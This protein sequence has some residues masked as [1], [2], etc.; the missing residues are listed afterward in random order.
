[1]RGFALILFVWAACISPAWAK[2]IYVATNGQHIA[3]FTN[4]WLAATNI[5]SAVDAAA[6]GDIVLV[7]MGT[8]ALPAP[9]NITKGLA[10]KSVHGPQATILSGRGTVRGLYL[11][12][13]NA[14]VEGF[15]IRSCALS[16]Y[17]SSIVAGA[18]IFV[19]AGA[20]ID[21]CII[22]S[23]RVDGYGYTGGNGYGGGA[24]IYAAGSVTIRN[25]LIYD[26]A[27]RGVGGESWYDIYM[28]SGPPGDGYGKGGGL[29]AAGQIN[30]ENC[31]IAGNQAVGVG[32]A[33]YYGGDGDGYAEGGGIF[34]ASADAFVANSIIQS[35]WA[36]DVIQN[37]TGGTYSH[38]CSVPQPEGTGNI[39]DSPQFID[40]DS[41]D[42]RLTS[43]SPCIG[44]G[45]NATV[46]ADRDLA[47][48]PRILNETVD[49]GSYE[50]LGTSSG[51]R[52]ALFPDEAIA[53]GA[54][55]QV[56][57]GAWQ[58]SGT[59]VAGLP[60]GVHTVHCSSVSG[61]V[62][63]ADQTAA[64]AT[65]QVAS[66]NSLYVQT[67][68][69]E[70]GVHP[71]SQTNIVGASVSFSIVAGGPDPLLYQWQKNAAPISGATASQY[72]LAPLVLSDSGAY[73]C[74]VSNAYGAITSRIANLLVLDGT[75]YVRQDNPTPAWPYTTWNT[76]ATNIQDAIDAAGGP[77]AVVLV[78]NGLYQTGGRAVYG[79][80]RVVIDKPIAMRSVNGPAVTIIQG[81]KDPLTTNGSAAVRCVW[82]TNNA[83]LAGFTLTNGATQ[84]SWSDNGSGGGVWCLSGNATISNCIL[85]GNSAYYRSGGAHQGTLNNCLLT[86]NI[87]ANYGGGTSYST[88]NN[89]TLS[90]NSASTYGGGSY[91]GSLNNTVIYFNSAPNGSNV[92][93]STLNS[94]CSSPLAG[95]VG[96]ID[97]DPLFLGR[98]SGDFRLAAGSPCIDKGSNALVQGS[99]DLNGQP[100]IAGDFVD[101]G[102]IEFAA[103]A[104]LIALE[105]HRIVLTAKEEQPIADQ[106]IQVWNGGVLSLD[107]SIA[108]NVPWLA[109]HPVSGSSTGKRDVVAV[110]FSTTGL[111]AG[112]HTGLVTIS[113]AQAD[114]SPRTVE[115]VLTVIPMVLDHF[116][117]AMI[118]SPQQAGVPFAVELAA[119][120]EENLTV[121]WF[122]NAVPL[123]AWK[124]EGVAAT[125][126]GI[127]AGSYSAGYPMGTYYNNQRTQVIYLAD[128]IGSACSITSLAL[129]VTAVPGQV[130]QNWTIRMKHTP[131]AL[132]PASPAWEGDGWTTAYQADEP[133]GTTGWRTF[134]FDAP[135]E[136]NGTD[137]LMVDFSF[138]C[139]YW[140]YYDGECQC[141]AVS[142]N[143][144]ITCQA[145][146]GYGDPLTWAGAWPSPY[147]EANIPNIQLGAIAGSFVPVAI[148]PE[149]TSAFTSGVWRGAITIGAETAD[150]FLRA[151]D[152]QGHRGDSVYFNVILALADS[153]GDGLPDQWEQ[154]HYG[155]PT[156]AN[157]AAWASNLLN[158]VEQAYLAGIDPNSPDSFFRV[159]VSGHT[160]AQ[161][162]LSWPWIPGRVYSVYWASNLISPQSW[163]FMADTPGS[164]YTDAV[165]NLAPRSVYKI[166]VRK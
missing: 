154:E 115:V 85:T 133:Q 63:P 2:T 3:P 14:R 51:L 4:S 130:M 113:S 145:D 44:A 79:F 117:W 72:A 112:V 80:T 160:P 139:A 97:L 147:A 46:S 141:S 70:I 9:I 146:S 136:Y 153:D 42:F 61:Y 108:T 53:G 166:K 159:S 110:S 59:F 75:N 19:Q 155:G 126:I 6:D 28:G 122:T 60:V 94:S 56:D 106:L 129:N 125:N 161:N 127:G 78:S 118:S 95:G 29:Y 21:S 124:A 1:M 102:A 144:T 77:G 24:G 157:P 10:L 31:T 32:G 107:Y 150:L 84:A 26:N 43:A 7:G 137:N 52:V 165:H 34:A 68:A 143:R 41:G 17:G 88:L 156:N 123:T 135:F 114:N 66:V 109:I 81:A 120:D 151:E 73:R 8:Y 62:T 49:M 12:H 148:S 13:T 128:E 83:S 163:I 116:A 134:V 58:N 65:G 67:A 18:G 164:S 15:T 149:T 158:T 35:N 111:A 37:W 36:G 20:F 57:G 105:P 76:A 40:V 74:L 101:M 91:Y 86:G 54:K 87:V 96:N 25:C 47:G 119:K 30:V 50:Y 90:D 23:N 104:P 142:A 5:Q 27:A 71:V 131:L 140:S 55:W 99:T 11:A 138:N 69:P 152:D 64:I 162:I 89:C 98:D 45:H 132:Y 48:N 33:G 103:S 92:W 100:R 93:G 38:S 121:F 22:Y 16:E 39:G 82:M